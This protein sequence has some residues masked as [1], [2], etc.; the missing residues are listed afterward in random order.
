MYPPVDR[1]VPDVTLIGYPFGWTGRAEHVRAVWRAL[2]AAGVKSKLY[3]TGGQ[4]SDERLEAE[5]RSQI[6]DQLPP[7]IRIYSLNG[8]E[9][10]GVLEALETRQSGSLRS[11]YNIVFPAWEL[12]R[13]PDV[14]ARELDRFDEVWTASPFADQSIRTAVT[15]PALHMPNAC[16]PPIRELIERS[17][18]GIPDDRFM[19]LF[20]FDLWSYTSR[21]NPWAAI[22][23]FRRLVAARPFAPVQLVIKLNNSS[24]DPSV[25]ERIV[26][27]TAD[28]GDRVTILDTILTD[29]EA[30][31]LVRCCDCFL[32]LHRSE[33]F[34]RGPAEAMFFGKSAVATGWSGNMEYMNSRVSFP[35]AYRLIPVN[36][37]EYP[38]SANQVWADPDVE[39][40][41][42]ILVRLVDNPAYATAVG[43]RARAHMCM[44]YSDAAIGKRYRARLEAI[45]AG[46]TAH[47]LRST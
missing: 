25:F 45:V 19:V 34:G 26:D 24:C 22:A 15:I 43:E 36:D 8:D 27:E 10:P 30:K 39:H 37:G 14:W 12:P 29:N 40:A 38:Y 18:F 6:V 7:G 31:N 44:N 13:Y 28:L 11:G 20:F 42:H 41:A 17:H 32:S 35:V 47:G 33:G 21:K 4:G 16:E 23:A 46:T 9:V 1:L 3:N 2:D 5:F